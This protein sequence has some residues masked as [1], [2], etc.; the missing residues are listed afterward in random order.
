MLRKPSTLIEHLTHS[1][2]NAVIDRGAEEPYSIKTL[3]QATR[4]N[5]YK[6]YGKDFEEHIKNL[7]KEGRS[8]TFYEFL[9]FFKF[10]NIII[11]TLMTLTFIIDFIVPLLMERFLRWIDD[12]NANKIEG[13][14]ILGV[15]LSIFILRLFFEYNSM[16]YVRMMSVWIKNCFEVRL[17]FEQIN[18]EFFIVVAYFIY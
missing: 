17:D 7:A 5:K 10:E 11:N 12:H 15:I 13:L 4:E 16:Y 14:V 18:F 1:E 6:G 3:L 8:L 9:K 2:C